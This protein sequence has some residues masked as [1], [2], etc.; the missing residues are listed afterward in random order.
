MKVAYDC[1]HPF[2]RGL[3]EELEARQ[4]REKKE[5]WNKLLQ[6]VHSCASRN[7]AASAFKL[8]ARNERNVKRRRKRFANPCESNVVIGVKGSF[9]HQE[10]FQEELRRKRRAERAL[11]ESL[12][13]KGMQRSAFQKCP[14]F[15]EVKVRR[16]CR[17]PNT[18]LPDAVLECA[19]LS[20]C[21]CH[22]GGS[23]VRLWKMTRC[24]AGVF[25]EC[26]VLH[27]RNARQNQRRSSGYRF[28]SHTLRM[29]IGKTRIGPLETSGSFCQ[30][31]GFMSWEL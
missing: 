11:L 24:F 4:E 15:S 10:Q 12:P 16:R 13:A 18:L 3:Q 23:S 9:A 25:T 30:L 14:L 6:I 29:R 1:W 21:S 17:A 19:P 5:L 8:P 20:V 27:F 31:P 7:S 22:A 2:L 26:F 28:A